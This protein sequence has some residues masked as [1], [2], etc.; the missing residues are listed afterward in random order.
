MGRINAQRLILGGL[1]AGAVFNVLEALIGGLLTTRDFE[2]ALAALGKTMPQTPTMLA[3]YVG[4]GFVLGIVLVWTYAAIRPRFGAGPRTAI[5]AGLT[6]WVAMGLINALAQAPMGIMPMRLHLLMNVAWL[7][8]LPL[9]TLA[10]GWVY[11]E[12]A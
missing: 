7:L 12:E 11:R 4:L 8:E 1:A 3:Y 5:I 6:V 10:G 2:A 9:A